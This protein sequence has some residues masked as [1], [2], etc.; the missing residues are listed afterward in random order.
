MSARLVRNAGRIADWAEIL[1]HHSWLLS[2]DQGILQNELQYT[3]KR[4]IRRADGSRLH[5]PVQNNHAAHQPHVATSWN[6]CM[7]DIVKQYWELL[8]VWHC[9]SSVVMSVRNKEHYETTVIVVINLTQLSP[10]SKPCHEV[11]LGGRST[12]STRKCSN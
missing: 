5:L 2:L 3:L 10:C 8:V 1:D 9:E 12:G 4:T 7:T 6:H 11:G